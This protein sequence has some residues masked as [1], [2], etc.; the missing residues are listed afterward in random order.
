MKKLIKPV[1]LL[2]IAFFYF[3]S[4][5]LLTRLLYPLECKG[6][7]PYIVFKGHTYNFIDMN[8]PHVIAFIV[9]GAVFKAYAIWF[10]IIG[11]LL[12]AVI[13]NSPF[14]FIDLILNLISAFIGIFITRLKFK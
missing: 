10:G 14:S 8:I 6:I 13:K 1:L 12:Q 5:S 11:E 3:F 7:I 4:G 2:F 9:M